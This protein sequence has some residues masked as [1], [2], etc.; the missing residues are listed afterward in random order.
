MVQLG[1]KVTCF[2]RN[3][4]NEKKN[5]LKE[6]KGIKI[7]SVP[8]LDIRGI[9]AASASLTAAVRAAFGKFDVVHFHAEGPCAMMW[10]PKLFGK[11]CVATIH[12]AGS[13]AFKVGQVCQQ[14]YFVRREMCS[15][16]C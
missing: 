1:C 3:G 13:S 11:R 7:V 8:T 16:I 10:I 9:A 4:K 12:W 14:I 2:N 15:K 6:Y 5:K